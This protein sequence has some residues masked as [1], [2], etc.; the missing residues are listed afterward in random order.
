MIEP[1]RQIIAMGGGGFSTEP[2]N[3]GLDAYV[4]GQARR[5]TPSVCFVGA[6]SGDADS[7]IA[8]FQLAGDE[9][10]ETALPV[11]QLS[12]HDSV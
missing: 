1:K 7:Y 11:E 2:D 10:V 6:A 12:K 4:V 8:R 5:K 3:L 9:T